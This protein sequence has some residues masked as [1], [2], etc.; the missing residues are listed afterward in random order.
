MAHEETT[1]LPVIEFTTIGKMLDLSQCDTLMFTSKKAVETA[2]EIDAS[3]K[4]FPTI[5]IGSATKKRIEALGGNV[6][7]S[8]ADFYA[9]VLSRD[10]VSFFNNNKIL[11]LRPEKV[12]FDI[13]NFLEKEGINLE[14]QIIYRTTCVHHNMEKQPKEGSIIIFTSPSTIT[15]FLENYQWSESY[16]AIVIGESTKEHLPQGA[17][18][19]VADIPL[20]ASCVKKAKEI[21]K[22]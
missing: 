1:P 17:K 16:I 9:K 3:W 15:C 14:E 7:Y 4:N 20:I 19:E 18:Y 6:I 8:P 22:L 13:K 2:D 12:S 5:A 10:V 11:Y 21:A